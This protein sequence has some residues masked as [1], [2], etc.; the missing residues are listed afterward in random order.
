MQKFIQGSKSKRIDT[1]VTHAPGRFVCL[2]APLRL[3]R[4][5]QCAQGHRRLRAAALEES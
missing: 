2:Q 5:G 4:L 3:H 1:S